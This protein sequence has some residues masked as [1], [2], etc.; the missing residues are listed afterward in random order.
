MPFAFPFALTL[1]I[2]V[3]PLGWMRCDARRASPDHQRGSDGGSEYRNPRPNGNRGPIS[4]A[5]AR[6]QSKYSRA[7]A[8]VGAPAGVG[9]SQ[10]PSLSYMPSVVRIARAEYVR[11]LRLAQAAGYRTRSVEW[12]RDESRAGFVAATGRTAQCW[13]LACH[14]GAGV[15]GGLPGADRRQDRALREPRRSS[16]ERRRRSGV[17]G[18]GAP[19]L[20]RPAL[21]R[22][23]R[24]RGRG[25]SPIDLPRRAARAR[26]PRLRQVVT[27]R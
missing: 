11:T 2:S 5:P 16:P 20:A 4:P 8:G 1:A 15:G 25:V 24:G 23:L 13:Q 14:S 9:R 27:L 21:P 17:A 26:R 12:R 19:H 10:R 22:H 3:P 6:A 7:W 18:S